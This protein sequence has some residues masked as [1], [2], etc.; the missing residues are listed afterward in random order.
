MTELLD[1]AFARVR[2][3]PEHDQDVFAA[4]LLSALDDGDV[5]PPDAVTRAAIRE[6]VDQARRG[7]LLTDEETAELWRRFDP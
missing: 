4:L 3:L 2:S 7:D 5:P 1:R 6:G